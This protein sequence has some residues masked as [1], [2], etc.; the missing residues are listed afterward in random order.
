[1]AR[2]LFT[3]GGT[4]G[5]LAPL[6][7]IAEELRRR[8]PE[9]RM[10]FLTTRNP[11]ESD[12]LAHAGF[13]G[14]SFPAG[15]W[16]RYFSLA[17]AWD[18]LVVAYAFFRSLVLFVHWR[19]AVIISA[20]SF[21]SVPVA[22]AGWI[23]RIP[24][25][26]HQQDVEP[27]LANRLMAP[28]AKLITVTFEPTR[29]HFGGHRAVW[30]GNPV[31]HALLQGDAQSARHSL[32]LDPALPV[33]LVLGGSSGAQALNALVTEASEVLCRKANIIHVLGVHAPA[34]LPTRPHYVP[35]RFVTTG[36]ADI[37][38]AADVVVSRAGI[39][40]ISE[41]A[42]LGKSVILVPMP[43]TH[44]EA[45]AGFLSDQNAARV[46]EQPR[47]SGPAFAEVVSSLLDRPEERQRY[48][49]ALRALAKPDAAA[50]IAGHLLRFAEGR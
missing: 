24:L 27:G 14:E 13:F 47:L 39:S 9:S 48:G 26:I 21:L 46:L 31:R 40:T 42:A 37:Y 25:A 17:N 6:I 32:G 43:E 28:T 23:F 44:Q 18:L 5:T 12:L 20:G 3:G 10:R 36:L 29:Q 30:T 19:P 1:M 41:L 15:K 22:W 50:A 2:F 33:I 35:L 8:F 34:S 45:N 16:R 4:G 7:A 38:A 11:A 49:V